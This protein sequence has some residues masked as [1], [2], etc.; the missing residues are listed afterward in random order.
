MTWR[1]LLQMLG[2]SNGAY[3]V[4]SICERF[5]RILSYWHRVVSISE[6][7]T[8]AC[9]RIS[10]PVAASVGL[11]PHQWACGH[12]SGPVA[13]SAYHPWQQKRGNAC[14]LEAGP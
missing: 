13:T 7:L 9:G 4:I 11:W 8:M 5:T 1:L 14:D 3:Q 12:I 2:D 6:G 10:G